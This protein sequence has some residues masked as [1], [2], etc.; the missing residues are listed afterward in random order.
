MLSVAYEQIHY[1]KGHF[2]HSKNR[3]R[4][5]QNKRIFMDF[6]WIFLENRRIFVKDVGDVLGVKCPSHYS[7]EE[8]VY[9]T[10]S[11][12]LLRSAK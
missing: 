6:S 12:Y 9:E 8:R 7:K 5:F 11:T 4:F 3:T 1:S 2:A 10:R